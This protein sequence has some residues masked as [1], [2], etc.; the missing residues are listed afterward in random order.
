MNRCAIGCLLAVSVSL[1]ACKTGHDKKTEAEQAIR[2]K[3]AQLNEAYAAK[4]PEKVAS[5]YADDAVLAIP[6]TPAIKGKP[7]IHEAVKQMETDPALKVTWM[8]ERIEVSESGDLAIVEGTYRLTMTDPASTEGVR[9]HGTYLQ[10]YRL[11]SDGDWKMVDD[12]TTSEPPVESAD[13]SGSGGTGSP[14]QTGTAAPS[15]NATPS[16][17]AAQTGTPAA[18]K[19]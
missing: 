2:S 14:G 19:Q 16:G 1:T 6:G 12:M 10:T 18:P 3:Q 4:D 7:A 17:T 9:D 11:A 13:A 8:P 15:A 5:H